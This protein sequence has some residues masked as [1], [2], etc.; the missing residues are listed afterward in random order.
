M[1]LT[2]E[3]IPMITQQGFKMN[4]TK[5]SDPKRLISMLYSPEYKIDE[6]NFWMVWLIQRSFQTGGRFCMKASTPS[7]TSS[8]IMFPA[9]TPEA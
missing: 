2:L 3:L 1:L 4:M 7:A 9:I 8:A 5:A 6:F